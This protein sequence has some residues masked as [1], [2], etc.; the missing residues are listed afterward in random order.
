MKRL[1]P[2][3]AVFLAFTGFALAQEDQDALRPQPVAVTYAQVE[4][5]AVKAREHRIKMETERQAVLNE[6]K[7]AAETVKDT[8]NDKKTSTRPGKQ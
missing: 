7:K 6:R 1:F 8:I 5:D 2:I 4:R 3:L